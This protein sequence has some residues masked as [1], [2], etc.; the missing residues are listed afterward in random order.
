MTLLEIIQTFTER[1]GLPR[2]ASVFGS[3]DAQILQIRG[4]LNEA[5][6]DLTTRWQWEWL[7]RQALFTTVEGEDQ[8]A[9][10]TIAPDGFGYILGETIFNRT[11]RLPVYGPLT[12]PQWQ[13]LKALPTTGPFYKYRIRGGRILFNPPGIAGQICAFEYISTWSVLDVDGTTYKTYFVND[14]DTSIF[15]DNLLIAALRWKWKEEKG[16]DYAEDFARYE[17]MATDAS[18]RD[19]TKPVLKMDATYSDFRPGI[20]VPSGN[21]P[22]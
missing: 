21:W 14:G 2:P 16:L 18:G 13:A 9:L 20:F 17:R 3:R 11:L 7:Q 6:E 19:A 10:T 4:L 5:L 12:P 1:T 15:A 8:G 22:V